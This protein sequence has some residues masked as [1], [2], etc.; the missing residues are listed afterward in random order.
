MQKIHM[1]MN[2][3]KIK[4][5][6]SKKI[7]QISIKDKKANFTKTKKMKSSI[8]KNHLMEKQKMLWKTDERSN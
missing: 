8:Q 4:K 2:D 5:R 1:I 7:C 6:K 3:G